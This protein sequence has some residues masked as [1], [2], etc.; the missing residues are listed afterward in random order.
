VLHLL[1][2]LTCLTTRFLMTVKTTCSYE[3]S[4]RHCWCTNLIKITVWEIHIN[5]GLRY[6]NPPAT[7]IHP[8]FNPRVTKLSPGMP[9]PA[10]YSGIDNA[11][12]TVS[13]VAEHGIKNREAVSQKSKCI[14]FTANIIL[15][16]KQCYSVHLL[17][18]PIYRYLIY[19]KIHNILSFL[20]KIITHVN[21]RG[22]WVITLLL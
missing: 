2:N 7:Q 20:K 3:V 10:E 1:L 9:S 19:W 18:S 4:N 6:W 22:H 17:N 12:Y 13:L 15:F 14:K 16:N 21:G 11:S 8:P 5:N